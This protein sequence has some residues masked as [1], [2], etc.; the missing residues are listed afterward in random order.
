M[1]KKFFTYKNGATASMEKLFPSGMYLVECRRPDGTLH[2][3]V[4]C[5][6]YDNA[7]A[8]LR[9]FKAIARNLGK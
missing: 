6:D 9:S 1:K 3:K 7:C 5:D 4:R 2:D 8:F